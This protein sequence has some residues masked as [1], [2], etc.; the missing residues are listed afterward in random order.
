MAN[1]GVSN[2]RRLLRAW[3]VATSAIPG[4]RTFL[5]S[6]WNFVL[7]PACVACGTEL[8]PHSHAIN[9][10]CLLCLACRQEFTKIADKPSCLRCGA[11]VGPYVNSENGCQ[12]CSRDRFAFKNVYRLGLYDGVLRDA[13][14][15]GKYPGS[16]PLLMSMAQ[17]IWEY[18]AD[19]LQNENIGLIVPIPQHW[20]Q[21]L[22]RQHHAPDVLAEAW[23]RCLQVPVGLPILSKRKWTR[24]QAHLSRADRKKNQLDVFRV[25]RPLRIAGK[26][27][28]LVDDVLTTGATADSAARALKAA[29]AKKVVVVVM[30]RVVGHH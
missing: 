14:L 20:W 3:D 10:V 22:R 11:P 27:I 26:T 1:S 29:G 18:H 8:G 16:E 5:S 4:F 15:K 13:V 19:S 23:G 12:E 7:P 6:G 28:L 9:S 30:A 21:R 17:L 24:K 2:W 25:H